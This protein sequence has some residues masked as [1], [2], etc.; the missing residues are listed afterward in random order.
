MWLVAHGILMI[1]YGQG[2]PHDNTSYFMHEI[3]TLHTTFCEANYGID[4]QNLY[5]YFD[6]CI[7]PKKSLTTYEDVCIL[8]EY[9]NSPNEKIPSL[10]KNDIVSPFHLYKII[11]INAQLKFSNEIF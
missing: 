9:K 2:I 3:V 8:I 6:K 1:L 7:D 10:K 4:R 5:A 11:F